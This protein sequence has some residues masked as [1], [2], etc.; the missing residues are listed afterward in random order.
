MRTTLDIDENLLNEA[1]KVSGTSTKKA[2]VEAGLHELLRKKLRQELISMA[3]KT[4]LTVTLK[5]LQRMRRDEE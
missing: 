2:T 4:E 3:G 1:M 5:D